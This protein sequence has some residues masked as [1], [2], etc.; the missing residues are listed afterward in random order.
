[1]ILRGIEQGEPVERH[2][3]VRGVT[4]AISAVADWPALV[5]L[6][7][8]HADFI[9]SNTGATGCHIA[10]MDRIRPESG[11]V[12]GGFIPK[13]LALLQACWQAGA[14]P[15]TLL[16]CELVQRNGEVLRDT[17]L[18]LARDWALERDCLDWLGR[19]LWINTLVDRIASR[20]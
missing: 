5:E 7:I 9:V 18:G 12:P 19:C 13:L 11:M 20:G 15:L 2:L 8:K 3:T 4:H 14:P 1:M 6:A 10:D 16:P 17:V